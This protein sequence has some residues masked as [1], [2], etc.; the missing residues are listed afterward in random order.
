M[1]KNNREEDDG[2]WSPV[3]ATGAEILQAISW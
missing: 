3:S 2:K 1:V